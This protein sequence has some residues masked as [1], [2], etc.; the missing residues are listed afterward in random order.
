[1]M[2]LR[3]IEP[4]DYAR[5]VLPQT[6]ALWAGRRDFGTYAAH[7]LEIAR[8]PY[9]RRHYRTAGLF[10]GATMLASFKRYERVMHAGAHR[11]RAVGIGAV[12]TPPE[13]RGHGYA[14]VML[15]SELDRAR[16]SGCD[17]AYLFSDIRP[18]FYAALGFTELP[19]RE[20]SLRADG[21]PAARL[22]LAPLE[23]RDWDA[24]RRCFDRCERRRPAG[25]LRTP[26]AWDWMLMRMRQGSER[27]GGQPTNLVVRRPGRGISAYVL[28][29]RDPERDAY[30]LDEFGFADDAAAEIVPALLRAAAGDLRRV[31]GW[32]PPGS[33]RELLPPGT[34]RKRRQAI[35][36]A[37]PLSPAGA[38]AVSAL[39]ASAASDPCWHA[40][41]I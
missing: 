8:S 36:M 13:R 12:F 38:L 7:T 27:A 20:V 31:V 37:A 21:L 14:S 19:S 35:F 26:L 2:R 18:Q 17:V 4:D 5:Q 40:D 10:D 23:E 9:G 30:A 41:H 16:A 3:D 28:G 29:A 15:G 32:L 39:A 6:A 11:L 1:M 24:V 25:F 34:V 22:N 33:A